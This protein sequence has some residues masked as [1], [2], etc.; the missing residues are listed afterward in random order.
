[1]EPRGCIPASKKGEGCE[2]P[3]GSTV[4]PTENSCGCRRSERFLCTKRARRRGRFGNEISS[5]DDEW[6]KE[7]KTMMPTRDLRDGP[8]SKNHPLSGI[9]IIKLFPKEGVQG[10]AYGG[11]PV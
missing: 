5:S 2:S 4:I 8:D 1:V 9:C 6:E 7:R 11:N 10:V 3:E